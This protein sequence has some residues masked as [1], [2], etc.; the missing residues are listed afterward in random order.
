VLKAPGK[1]V[2]LNCDVQISSI[3]VIST[4]A[5]NRRPEDGVRFP[6]LQAALAAVGQKLSR[7]DAGNQAQQA[8][9]VVAR[10]GLTLVH[11]SAQPDPSLSLSPMLVE[12]S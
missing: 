9:S 5:T 7:V 12:L 10:Q 11:S 2:T 1:C 4:Y 6:S 3:F 8:A